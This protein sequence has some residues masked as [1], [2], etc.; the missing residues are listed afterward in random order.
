MKSKGMI[1]NR[2]VKENHQG[3]IERVKQRSGEGG[4]VGQPGKMVDKGHANWKRSNSAM[5]PRKG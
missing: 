3:G 4:R 1:D 2:M 5:T